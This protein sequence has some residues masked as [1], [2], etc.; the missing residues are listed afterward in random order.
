MAKSKNK[1]PNGKRFVY[2]FK[3]GE[4]QD[5]IITGETPAG[6]FDLVREAKMATTA[7]GFN[8]SNDDEDE[9]EDSPVA[10]LKGQAMK[11]HIAAL[12]DPEELNKIVEL[13]SRKGAKEAA[14]ARL[15]ELG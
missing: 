6:W 4:L 15:A 1:E 10:N 9:G 14:T 5:Q 13:D 3:D 8:D 12:E 7:P 11:E 2:R